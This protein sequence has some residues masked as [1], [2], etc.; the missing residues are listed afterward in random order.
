MLDLKGV[1]LYCDG[2]AKQN[3]GKAGSGVH[4]YIFNY[5]PTNLGSGT[6]AILTQLGYLDVADYAKRVLGKETRNKKEIKQAVL[7][8]DLFK[9]FKDKELNLTTVLANSNEGLPL[10]I[11]PI[12]YVDAWLSSLAIGTNNTAE[13]NAVILALEWLV[14][15][16]EHIYT[17][18]IKS[19]SEYVIKGI[20]EYLDRWLKTDFK[21]KDGQSVAN[22]E[23][24]LKL[25]EL[26]TKCN[27]L[28]IKLYWNWVKGHADDLGNIQAD[29]LATIAY[30]VETTT[31]DI[32]SIIISP[33]N[34][35]W[36]KAYDKPTLLNQRYIL[37]NSA[38][39]QDG[40]TYFTCNLGNRG[41]DALRYIGSKHAE[42]GYS[43]VRLI[44]GT[45]TSYLQS[46]VTKQA[47]LLDYE[48]CIVALDTD[49]ALSS[50][51]LK[52]YD[53]A[54]INSICTTGKPL[55]ELIT[56]DRSNSHK[57][58]SHVLRPALLSYKVEQ[59]LESLT[60]LYDA[61]LANTKGLVINDITDLIY[62][63]TKTTKKRVDNFKY[64]L[65]PKL[66]VGSHR[67]KVEANYD[68]LV[69]T[70]LSKAEII[71]TLGQDI[72]DRNTLKRLESNQPK[73]SL[74]TLPLAPHYFRY[75]TLIETNL[76]WSLSC[77]AYT[78]SRILDG[79]LTN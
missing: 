18:R 35:Y 21:R 65:N 62:D 49:V 2:G 17:A 67:L 78:N 57:A 71:L 50:D 7:D 41:D 16:P 52:D 47:K 28:D 76:G 33:A 29:R 9:D 6:Q 59:I 39:E 8:L 5:K 54:G 79:R 61:Y 15:Y 26:I 58:I 74:L 43:L 40:L 73:V 64:T 44:D 72:P 48:P 63:I 20:T 19:D 37:F 32:K 75:A 3:P 34:G 77:G 14:D 46:L 31:D 53:L 25:S 23:L 13:L 36:S 51:T 10:E 55:N 22:V 69:N 12:S 30:N 56:S 70:K 11:T 45:D 68:N 1:V 60:E 38:V 24:W 66:K 42:T 4:G 27:N